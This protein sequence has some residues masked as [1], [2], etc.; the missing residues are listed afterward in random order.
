MV[1]SHSQ[2]VRDHWGQS[3]TFVELTPKERRVPV[4]GKRNILI[5]SALPYVNNVPHLGNIIGCVLSADVFARYC[6]MRGH[7]TLYVCGTD[8]YGTATET[9]ALQ[10]GMTPKEVCDKYHVIHKEIYEWFNIDF[11]IFGRTTT[12]QQTEIAQD[13]FL[14]LHQNG[15]TSS[16]SID[17]LHCRNCDK[18]LADRFVTGICPFCAY[19]DARGDQCDSCGRL[20]NAVELKSPKCHICKQEP[21]VRQSTHI[22]LH[23]DAL[24]EDVRKYVEAEIAKP[25]TRWSSNAIAIVKGWIKGGLE[26]R[27]IT[28][29]LKWGTA[30]PLAGYEDKVF[31]VWYDAPIGY[32][33]IT[34]CL[35]GDNWTKWW[36]NPKNVELYNFIGKDNVA[37]HGV[38][39]PC[40]QLGARDNYTIVNHV[41][42][43]E[44]LNY[45]D[46]K[47]SKSRNTGVFGD[48]AK[49]TGIEA[50]VWRFY[51]LYVRPESQDTSFSWDDFALKVNSELLANLG[52][53]INRALSFLNNNFGGTM[54]EMHLTDVDVELL[55]GIQ[56]DSVEWDQMMDAVRQKDAVRAVLSM[57]RRG[58]QYMQSQQPWVLMKGSEVDKKRAGTVIGIGANI[59]YH[60]AVVL[61]PIMPQVSARIR[62]QCGLDALPAFSSYPISYLKPGHK[63]GTPKPLF[64][65]MENDKV[66]E[67]K[68]RFG[69]SAK[70]DDAQKKKEKP[71][72]PQA[73]GNSKKTPK[74]PENVK[75]KEMAAT[76]ANAAFPQLAKNQQQIRQMLEGSLKKF[77]QARDLFVKQKGAELAASIAKLQKEVDDVH[78]QLVEAETAAGIKQIPV[79]KAAKT[80]EKA[81]PSPSAVEAKPPQESKE[82]P[83]KKEKS[84][85]EKKQS[86][87]VGNKKAEAAA[88]DDTIDVGRLDLRVGRIVKCEK[89]PDADALYVEQ[90]DVGEP[91]P[92]T[93]VSGL[94]R[95]VPLDQM[96]NRL[97]VVL[98]N[99]KPAKMRGVESR[100]MV[101]CASSPEKV[102]IM[103]VDP[104]SQPGTPVTCPPYVHRP[105]AQLNPKKK[106]WETV[107]EDLKVSPDGYAVWKDTPLLIGGVTKMTAP[108]LRG[109]FIK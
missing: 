15:Y 29:D 77:N 78:R 93:V 21:K 28:R 55:A 73:N 66:A 90:I 106:I 92:R 109:V 65:K 81:E 25:N 40:T 95:H 1:V 60:L 8:E 23:L 46:T 41:C 5:T 10:E 54:P 107:A 97:V 68:A 102:E 13:I 108:S 83:S 51:L 14:K 33:S 100:A 12:P 48:N 34:K 86:A 79:Q 50:D 42:A 105:D 82:K 16:S 38:M 27:C 67:W 4:Q 45:E 2:Q 24:Q 18:F 7:E 32:L 72:Q 57:S 89:H 44:Y 35:V 74:K 104:S 71:K 6:R 88:G 30:V 3:P 61:H 37:F 99:L 69:G 103:E 96:Q 49:D 9:K 31:Y 64:T 56:E 17:Q 76:I 20:I 94:V 58:N 43:T 62:S 47:F 91:A 52:N 85:T 59:A 70:V 75:S 53:F 80:V 19:D 63:I 87:A 22:F 39:F 11:D 36:K 26:K 98:C 84:A 101:M